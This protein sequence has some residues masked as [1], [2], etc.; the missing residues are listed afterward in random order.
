LFKAIES[1]LKGDFPLNA[2]KV[3]QIFDEKE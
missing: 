3:V 1:F 2:E